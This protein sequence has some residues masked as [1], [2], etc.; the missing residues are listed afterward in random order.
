LV[1]GISKKIWSQSEED[2]LMLLH[3]KYGNKWTV[4]ADHMPGRYIFDNSEPIIA[5][6]IISTQLSEEV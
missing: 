3:K 4:I 6:K 1:P 5:L 2:K